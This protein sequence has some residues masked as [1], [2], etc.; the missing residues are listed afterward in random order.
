MTE[1][2]WRSPNQYAL[3]LVECRSVRQTDWR[4]YH[5]SSS[6]EDDPGFA[7]WK[8]LAA[9]DG[10]G[11]QMVKVLVGG[12]KAKSRLASSIFREIMSCPAGFVTRHT[13]RGA[14]ASFYVNMNFSAE[15][16]TWTSDYRTV[17]SLKCPSITSGP[18][19]LRAFVIGGVRARRGVAPSPRSL[20]NGC[21][22][23][24]R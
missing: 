5:F 22:D 23:L 16:R 13:R 11:D 3:P 18:S 20:S 21:H 6:L 15:S 12:E 24:K 19:D 9:V 8:A 14:V 2:A 1:S 7:P 17:S 10:N 4:R